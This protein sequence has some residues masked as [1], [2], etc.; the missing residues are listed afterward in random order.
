M[1]RAGILALTGK[2]AALPR[3]VGRYLLLAGCMVRLPTSG[4]SGIAGTGT[5]R[6]GQ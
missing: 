3:A 1:T 5:Q 2:T 6:S 4:R